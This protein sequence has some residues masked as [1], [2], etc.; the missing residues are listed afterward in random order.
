[1]VKKLPLFRLTIPFFYIS[2]FGFLVVNQ[3]RTLLNGKSLR[4]VFLPQS[5]GQNSENFQLRLPPPNDGPEKQENKNL[6]KIMEKG[7]KSLDNPV[8]R[9]SFILVL[10]NEEMNFFDQIAKRAFMQVMSREIKP[11]SE[12][13]ATIHLE[14]DPGKVQNKRSGVYLI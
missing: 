13:L 1:M 5:L 7:L 12:E 9:G 3:I 10:T 2:S 11:S 14:T 4:K 8:L 6:S